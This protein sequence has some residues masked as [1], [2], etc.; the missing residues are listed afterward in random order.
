MGEAYDSQG[1]LLGTAFGETKR[2]VFDNLIER[3]PD[4]PEIIIRSRGEKVSGQARQA[5][6]LAQL[7]VTEKL[8]K[9][10]KEREHEFL[11]EAG[12]PHF[13]GVKTLG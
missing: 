2:E 9:L 6:P 10:E 13:P 4:A 8:E 5:S 7:R 12:E 11:R 1:R 3:F